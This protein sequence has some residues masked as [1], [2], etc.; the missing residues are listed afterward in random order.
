M[1]AFCGVA[2][3]VSA[4]IFCGVAGG[5]SSAS[6]G[7]TQRETSDWWW[8]YQKPIACQW[9]T[10]SQT[11]ANLITSH[12]AARSSTWGETKENTVLVV[13][14]PSTFSPTSDKHS[15]A[16]LPTPGPFIL[17]PGPVPGAKQRKTLCWQHST[18]GTRERLLSK[19]VAG[20]FWVQF[21]W[22]GKLDQIQA[23]S[24][25]LSY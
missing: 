9:Q 16:L 2:S 25:R 3:G 23:Q 1:A 19:K 14:P 5:V 18:K 20:R 7:R 10:L 17:L 12:P 11:A 22:G 13:A 4:T 24:R 8:T 15:L 6:P 21:F